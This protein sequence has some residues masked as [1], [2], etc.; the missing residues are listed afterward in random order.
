MR[1]QEFLN[2]RS[3]LTPGLAGALTMTISNA[4]WLEFG[5]P[6]KYVGIAISFLIGV[7]I[8]FSDKALIKFWQRL[9]F[10]VLNSLLIFSIAAGITNIGK[11]STESEE[12]LEKPNS[13]LISHTFAENRLDNKF[14][15]SNL[16]HLN[17]LDLEKD[18]ESNN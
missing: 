3:M 9:V 4:L 7:L 8:V 16:S 1:T 17:I 11:I 13:S 5:L 10:C 2:S 15:Y 14:K 12:K 18:K 6:Q